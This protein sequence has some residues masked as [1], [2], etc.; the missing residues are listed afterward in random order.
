MAKFAFRLATLLRLREA[1]RDDRRAHLAE[2]LRA[3]E[4]LAERRQTLNDELRELQSRQRSGSFGHLNV[5]ALIDA[6]R[7]T[8]VL[9]SQMKQADEQSAIVAAEIE[10]RRQSLTLADRDVRVLERLRAKQ[11]ERHR[12]QQSLQEVKQLDEVAGHAA[13]RLEVD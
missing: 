6:Q 12:Q 11:V 3:Q 8:A 1:T 5:D 7:Y 13:A 9:Q 10:R 4:I 2:A